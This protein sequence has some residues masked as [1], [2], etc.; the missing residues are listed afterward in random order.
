MIKLVASIG[1]V[2]MVTLPV[3]A[4][5]PIVDAPTSP[6]HPLSKTRGWVEK[7]PQ[8]AVI[9]QAG[10]AAEAARTSHRRARSVQAFR[11]P[12]DRSLATPEN[13]ANQLNQQ[14]LGRL[15]VESGASQH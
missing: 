5:S 6:D 14:E 4:K 2:L 13:G 9:A 15:S 1:V 3:L 8:S 7:P 10:H 11:Q 12:R